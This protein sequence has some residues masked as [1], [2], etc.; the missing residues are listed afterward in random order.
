MVVVSM[1]VKQ[2]E[3]IRNV[4]LVSHSG[5]GKTSLSEAMLYKCNVVE[6]LGTVEEGSTSSDWTPEEKERQ[7]SFNATFLPAIYNNH[8]INIIDAPGYSDFIGDVHSSMRA[9]DS[10][11]VVVCA[12]SGV[13]IDTK[14]Y[15]RMTEDYKLP[16]MVFVNKLDRESA[17]YNRTINQLQENFGTKVVPLI[18]PIGNAE[19]FD[20]LVDI[21]KKKTFK[22]DENGKVTDQKDEIAPE[23]ADQAEEYRMM[24]VEALAES[25]DELL[26]KYLEDEPLT[27]EELIE[28]LGTA[29]KEGN[30][31]PVLSGLATKCT[32]TELLMDY[33]IE[34][35]PAPNEIGE[36][37][38]F[39]PG[40]EEEEVREVS[41]DAPASAFVIKTIVDPF[42]GRLSIFKVLSGVIESDT[43]YLNSTKDA[44]EKVG[45]V[46]FMKGKEQEQTEKVIAGDIAAVAKLDSA[47]TGDTLCDVDNPIMYE[48]VEFPAPMYS[49]AIYPENEKEIEKVG[50]GLNKYS[51][52]DP[53]FTLEHNAETHEMVVSCMGTQHIAVVKDII[54]RKFNVSFNTQAPK[55]PYRETI[56]AKTEAEVKYKKQSGGKGQYG[57]VVMRMEPLKRGEGFKFEEEIFGGAIPNQYIPAV[58]KGINETMEVGTIAGY[59]VVDFKVVLYD[60][61]YHPVD[62]S[63]MAFKI[64]GS[65]AF[66][67]GMQSARPTLL[68]P[69]MELEI[70]VPEDMMG[71][72]MGHMNSKRG[73]ILGMEPIDEGQL[74]HAQAPLAEVWDYAIELKSMTGGQGRFTMKQSHYDKVPERQAQEIIEARATEEEE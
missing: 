49:V 42:V 32:G 20:G 7:I 2:T 10:A 18:I 27:D 59:P 4:A 46:Y 50:T 37:K 52:E 73:R 41:A 25:D 64:A 61:S 66:K 29:V 40:T 11:V 67:Q 65:K 28:A 19:D 57:H 24:L 22:F 12:A 13:E 58:E 47:R 5:A 15:W 1:K 26:M 69:V 34:V 56:T 74:I 54:N 35:F 38:G 44:S 16:K 48:D 6:R 39:K 60:G 14:R 62:S 3:N 43:E 63:E 45:K 9:A 31:V 68:E 17:D 53:T 72:V 30:L 70:I 8:K 71:D 55:I 36:V 51:E 23:V 33:M 21:L